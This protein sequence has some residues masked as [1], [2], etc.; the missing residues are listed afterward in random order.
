MLW[1]KHRG[2]RITSTFSARVTLTLTRWPSYTN[3][4]RTAWRY[5]KY[6]LPTSRLS[7]LII[8]QT[9]ATEIIYYAASWVVNYNSK[10]P[11]YHKIEMYDYA[12]RNAFDLALNFDLWPWKPFYYCPLIRYRAYDSI[13]VWNTKTLSVSSVASR[14]HLRSASRSLLVMSRHRLSSHGRWAFSVAGPA[15]WNWLP[16]SLRDLAISR[17]SFKRSLKTISF[18]AYSCT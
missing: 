16:D 13:T 9:E 5:T 14:Q 18:W 2:G 11:R 3:L 12:A 8:W 4:T 1:L 15:I 7:K 10:S 6:K 17:D